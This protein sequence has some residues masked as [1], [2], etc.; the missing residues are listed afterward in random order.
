MRVAG[1]PCSFGAC[2]TACGFFRYGAGLVRPGGVRRHKARRGVRRGRHRARRAVRRT[3]SPVPAGPR[4]YGPHQARPPRRRTTARGAPVRERPAFPGTSGPDTYDRTGRPGTMDAR[5]RDGARPIRG[6]T[7]AATTYDGPEDVRRAVEVRRARAIRERAASPGRSGSETYEAP[8]APG[9]RTDGAVPAGRAR[10]PLGR[11]EFGHPS[12]RRLPAGYRT[13]RLR[14]GT[15]PSAGTRPGEPTP[16]A[17]SRDPAR[18]APDGR[19]TRRQEGR[20]ARLRVAGTAPPGVTGS[21][22]SRAGRTSKATARDLRTP[23]P[24]PCVRHA[25]ASRAPPCG[26]RT[27]PPIPPGRA[28]AGPAP[29]RTHPARR[30]HESPSGRPGSG[31]VRRGRGARRRRPRRPG[32]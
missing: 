4:A 8:G 29:D 7:T 10:S 14:P 22:R 1:P 9:P 30:R 31:A 23:A 24:R 25:S 15:P 16:Q 6:R 20:P 26:T 13:P 18:D 17:P 12:V 5:R 2:G 3:A 11:R 19:R 32:R 28:N 21:G 27:G